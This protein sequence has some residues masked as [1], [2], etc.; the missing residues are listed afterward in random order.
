MEELRE[1]HGGNWERS[2][3]DH[4]QK[5]AADV[6]D[7]YIYI[8]RSV[9]GKWSN[10]RNDQ[11]QE[12]II[13]SEHRPIQRIDYR[14]KRGARSKEKKSR[15]FAARSFR[16]CRAC[17]WQLS[18]VAECATCSRSPGVKITFKNRN[19]SRKNST[20]SIGNSRG[21]SARRVPPHFHRFSRERRAWCP[22][23]SWHFP[24]TG[25]DFF[26]VEKF[27]FSLGS[28]LLKNRR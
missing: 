7:H 4:D 2:N 22:C 5:N 14:K 28:S 16:G 13:K 15:E 18:P 12:K 25:L 23:D 26:N 27:F 24:V 20:W 17:I 8:H 1:D 21:K 10:Q 6:R 19:D 3:W 11:R 9:W